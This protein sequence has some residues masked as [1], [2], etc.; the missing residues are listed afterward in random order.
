MTGAAEYD[1]KWTGGRLPVTTKEKKKVIGDSSQHDLLSQCLHLQ[2]S[3]PDS[4]RRII[5][6]SLRSLKGGRSR[7]T[8][9]SLRRLKV[10]RSR[11]TSFSLKNLKVGRSRIT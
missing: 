9:F 11:I 3:D 1:D 2:R 8:S 10:G 7:I 5:L 4:G 6:F